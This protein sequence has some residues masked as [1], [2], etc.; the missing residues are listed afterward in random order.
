MVLEKLKN[1]LEDKRIFAQQ[2]IL[3]IGFKKKKKISWDFP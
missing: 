3:S 2:G 1:T